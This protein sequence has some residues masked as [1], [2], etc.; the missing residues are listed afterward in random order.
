MPSAIASLHIKSSCHLNATRLGIRYLAVWV[1]ADFYK[2][3]IFAHFS[4]S[5][6][7]F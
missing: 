6:D 4:K 1:F 5:A 2:K 3:S 7:F